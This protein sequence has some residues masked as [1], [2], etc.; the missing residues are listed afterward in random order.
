[1]EM[2]GVRAAVLLPSARMGILLTLKVVVKPSMI[3]VGPAYVCDVVHD[4][5][6]L[7]GAA[8]RFTDTS[9]GGFL[10]DTSNL[11]VMP[12]TPYALILSDIY[13]IPCNRE[14][15]ATG[16]GLPAV[17]IWDMAMSIP[18]PEVLSRMSSN[19][20][21][22][23]SFGLGKC[24]YSGWGGVLLS[25]NSHLAGCIR[26]LRDDWISEET[27]TVRVRHALSLLSRTAVHKR[28]LYGSSRAVANWWNARGKNAS[29]Q[30]GAMPSPN[31]HV[32]KSLPPEWTEPMTPLNRKI[33]LD[34]LQLA[35]VSCAL[36]QRQAEEYYR[37]LGPLGVVRGVSEEALPQSHFPI[38]IAPI[39]RNR[40]RQYL[41]QRG[42]DTATLFPFPKM[43]RRAEY[44]HTAR[45]SNE[46]VLLPLGGQI[47]LS[48]VVAVAECVKDVLH[49]IPREEHSS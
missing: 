7:S 43:L 49:R 15:S 33:A 20:V 32:I 37:R 38:C 12:R 6:L 26:Q 22:L 23:M 48:E 10:M 2:L 16:G 11:P 5:M 29:H 19:E 17:R 31:A 46:V 40:V 25:N 42:V 47:G 41:R 8:L 24:L 27:S 39:A 30:M 45:A 44:P 4:A 3:V 13:G 9:P 36:R 28:C 14:T 18:Q 35:P 34:N 21:A 1:M